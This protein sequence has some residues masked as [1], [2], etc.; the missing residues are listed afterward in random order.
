MRPRQHRLLAPL[1]ALWWLITWPYRL[2]TQA[3][4]FLKQEPD[5]RSIS[6]LVVN[7]S[8]KSEVRMDL[9]QHLE[10]LRRHLFRAVIWLALGVSVGVIF[11]QP[12]LDFLARPVGGVEQLRAIDVTEPIGVFMRVALLAGI[13]LAFLPI[14]FEF[15]L[16]AAPGLRPAEKAWSLIAIPFA[17]ALFVVG[18]AFAYYVLLPN[19]LPLLLN[20]AGIPV[21]L[22]PSSYFRFVTGLMFWMGVAFEFPILIVIL[23]V[24][25]LVRPQSLMEHARLA[26]VIFAGLAAIITPTVDPVNMALVWLP[27]VGLY[28]LSIGLS[29]LVVFLRDRSIRAQTTPASSGQ[30]AGAEMPAADALSDDAPTPA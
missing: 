8:E 16:F 18:M 5:E 27:T 25:R 13:A 12:I 3:I 15:W 30:E 26:V 9:L 2:L 28:F 7:L 10:V 6:D 29:Y 4:A 17:S 20:V 23:T 14:L 1:R 24:M 22:R 11:S 19:G 21:E